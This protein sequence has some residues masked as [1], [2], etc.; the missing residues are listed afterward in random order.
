[1][2]IIV[3]LALNKTA[4]KFKISVAEILRNIVTVICLRETTIT[5]V[6]IVT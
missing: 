4:G 1:M 2:V 6:I 5:H 3:V